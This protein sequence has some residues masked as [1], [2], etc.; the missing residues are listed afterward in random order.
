LP[1]GGDGN[2]VSQASGGGRPG[3]PQ[4]IASLRVAIEAGDWDNARFVLPGGQSGNPF[5]RHY[6]DML[7][8][9]L[10]G[11]GVPIPWS[12]EAVAAATVTTLRLE[13]L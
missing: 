11:Q 3:V 10:R 4:V 9:W 7:P 12:A 2:T 1:W 5:S 6:D 13:P 8:L